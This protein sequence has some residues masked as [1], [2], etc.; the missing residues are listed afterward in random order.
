MLS[1]KTREVV[2]AK[3][4]SFNFDDDPMENPVLDTNPLDQLIHD[5]EWMY[6]K[7]FEDKSN[8]QKW[9]SN[10]EETRLV[11]MYERLN[12]VV[13]NYMKINNFFLLHEVSFKMKESSTPQINMGFIKQSDIDWII[14]N[15]KLTPEHKNEFAFCGKHEFGKGCEKGESMWYYHTHYPFWECVPK[16]F[17]LKH[18]AFREFRVWRDDRLEKVCQIISDYESL[19]INSKQQVDHALLKSLGINDLSFLMLNK[20]KPSVCE[21]WTCTVKRWGFRIDKTS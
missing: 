1:S 9:P 12:D 21:E 8:E 20:W 10:K 2:E 14:Q 13:K 17:S 18:G 16:F 15:N 19:W 4:E 6:A 5:C 7:F 3:R 11:W